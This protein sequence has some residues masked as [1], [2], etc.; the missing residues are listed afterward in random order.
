[1][2]AAD[3]A[4]LASRVRFEEKRIFAALDRREVR[5]VHLDPRRLVGRVGGKPG[6]RTRIPGVPTVA[7][8]LNREISLTRAY[9]AALLFKAQGVPTIN[10]AEVISVCGDKLRTS[11]ELER[12][13]LPTPRTAL[14]LTPE[15]AADAVADI[16]FPAVVKPLTGSWGRLAALV[17]DSA[18]AEV[19]FEHRSALPSPQQH[20]LYLQELIDK[21]DRDIRVLVIGDRVV[22]AC[23][24]YADGWR[25]N[26]S[27]G[28]QSVRCPL[29]PEL[30]ELALRAAAAVGGGILGVDL[31]EGPDDL[32]VL[33]VNHATEF[34]GL[35]SAL[36]DEVDVA[37]AIVGFVLEAA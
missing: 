7:T 20:V 8:A 30:T 23:Y 25:T 33:E 11:F 27:R 34:R 37:D 28:A 18:E 32:H 24:R 19:V 13:G 15:A 26:A 9:Y 21:P 4:V 16:G 3:L 22:G 14:A 35:Q 36:G 1:V 31:V 29:T 6:A 2:T 5:Y 12:A 10:R 17:R